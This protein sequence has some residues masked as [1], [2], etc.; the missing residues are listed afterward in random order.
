[1]DH[2]LTDLAKNMD[3]IEIPEA[4]TQDIS[5]SRDM[6]M[7]EAIRGYAKEVP[8]RNLTPVYVDYKKRRTKLM[9]V[10]CPEWAPEFPPFNL[11]RLSGV[12]KSAGFETKILDLN[13]RAFNQHEEDWIPNGKLPFRLWNPAA[14]WHWLGET[15]MHDIH[16]V[17][18]PLLQQGVEEIL[19]ERPHV[20]GFSQYYISEEPTK[21][22]AREIKRRDPSI[23]IA[24]GGSNAHKDWFQ[25][26]PEYDYVVK[27][28][29]EKAILEILE[30]IE[31]GVFRDEP[32]V[33]DQA[34]QERININGLPMPDYESIDFSQYRVPNGVT[35]EFSRGCT[36]KCTFCEETHFWKYRQ[37]TAVDLIDEM[38]WLYYNKGVDIVWFIDSLVNGNV[39]ELRAFARAVKAKELPTKWT[40]YSRMDGRMDAEYFRD[41]ADGGCVMLNYGCESGSQRVLDDMVKGVTIKEM[42]DN[43]RDGSAVGIYAATNWIVG[44]PT[45]GH[46]DFAQTMSF[47]WRNR[48]YKIN[49]V[50]AGVG[51]AVG[52]ATIVGQNPHKYNVSH[53]KYLG[54]W[55][56][57]DFTIGGT[58]VMHRVKFFHMF[59]DFMTGCTVEPF[60]FPMRPNLA[61]EHYDITLNN[62]DTWHE[63]EYE[64]F[65]YQIIRP[66]ISPFADALVNEIWP[67]LRTLWLTRGGFSGTILF[68][69][70]IDSKEFGTQ[71]GPAE[72][73]RAT[74]KFEITD[75]GEWHADFDYDFRQLPEP[76]SWLEPERQGAF[77][78]QEY[79][80]MQSNAAKRARK[81][82]RPEWDV[83]T[84]RDDGQFMDMLAEER[85]LNETIDFTF[86]YHYTGSG[87][88]HRGSDDISVPDTIG[89]GVLG[90][91]VSLNPETAHQIE[92]KE[93]T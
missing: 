1:M 13:V 26:I 61:L 27:G 37:R 55:I 53:H 7:M 73:F 35:S 57:N 9:L 24:V 19:A 51:M 12:C 56:A 11:A 6:A 42:E 69:P 66:G 78:A 18:E 70:E 34:E 4:P 92:I 33:L 22:M 40:G 80:R 5:D 23:R 17:L 89:G 38:E 15:Y 87:K 76:E 48:N 16:P 72:T 41:L 81:L 2:N 75:D 84:G 45:E 71:F 36:A 67:F 49:N 68:N 46:S 88:W 43:L 3:E 20:V 31:D 62:P 21:W 77:F 30:E 63:V 91:N 25:I 28:E 47:L 54:H 50:G 10:L 82:A 8:Q 39:K 85:Y 74:Y 29:G 83:K 14:S 58:H 90:K 64:N 79:S 65:D 52:P 60:T 59:L 44:F 93:I 86:K 32:L